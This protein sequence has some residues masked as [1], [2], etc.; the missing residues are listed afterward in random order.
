MYSVCP[1]CLYYK[2]KY[3]L[4]FMLYGCII[5]QYCMILTIF[6]SNDLDVINTKHVKQFKAWYFVLN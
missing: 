5:C 3:V 1:L 4:I 6:D 2:Q